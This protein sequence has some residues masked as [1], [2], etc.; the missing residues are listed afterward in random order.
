M[1]LPVLLKAE[2]IACERG[3]RLVFTNLSFSVKAGEL[4]ELRGP[5]GSGKSTLLRLLAGLNT[6]SAGSITLD[7]GAPDANIAEQAHY[8][9][10]A[11]ANKPALTA[12]EN[13]AFWSRFLGG[14][15][16]SLSAFNLQSLAADQTLHLSA[17]QKRRLALAR[18]TSAPRAIWLLDEPDVGLDTASRL[19]LKNHIAEHLESGGIV[20]AATHMELGFKTARR[21]QLGVT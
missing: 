9:G 19:S 13:L 6:Q 20:L 14:D 15:K 17:G 5:N 1:A 2:N 10:H 16:S 12:Q 4:L 3:G 18:L 11:D 7:N 21:L 8:I